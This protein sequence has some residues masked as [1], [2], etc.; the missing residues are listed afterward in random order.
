MIHDTLYG[1]NDDDVQKAK[2]LKT[3]RMFSMTTPQMLIEEEDPS[4]LNAFRQTNQIAV[5]VYRY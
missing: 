5:E 1:D 3:W 4:L 2:M